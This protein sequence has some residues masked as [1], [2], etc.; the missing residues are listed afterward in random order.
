MVVKQPITVKHSLQG[1]ANL[2]TYLKCV[3][4]RTQLAV[5]YAIDILPE[6]P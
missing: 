4:A 1:N 2:P 6:I 3:A 5:A